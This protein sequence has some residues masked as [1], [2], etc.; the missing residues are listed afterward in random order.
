MIT[1]RENNDSPLGMLSGLLRSL[2]QHEARLLRKHF[3][4]AHTDEFQ[5]RVLELIDIVSAGD[6]LPDQIAELLGITR[7][8]LDNLI[9]IALDRLTFFLVSEHAVLAR[10]NTHSLPFLIEYEV[11]MRLM[12]AKICITRGQQAMAFR[13]LDTAYRRALEGEDYS[14]AAEVLA[15]KMQNLKF[16]S[17]S[18]E[19]KKLDT[20]HERLRRCAEAVDRAYNVYADANTLLAS[21]QHAPEQVRPYVDE[22][23]A[24]AAFSGSVQVKD[25]SLKMRVFYCQALHQ[26]EKALELSYEMLAMTKRSPLLSGRQKNGSANLYVASS[27]LLCGQYHECLRFLSIALEFFQPGS[28]NA[29]LCEELKYYALFYM[30]EYAGAEKAISNVISNSDYTRGGWLENKKHYL[31]A[32]ALFAQERYGECAR[33]LGKVTEVQK[34]KTGWNFGMRYMTVMLTV[35]YGDYDRLLMLI[36]VYE[37]DYMRTQ[38]RF[39]LRRREKLI[40]RLFTSLVRTNSFVLTAEDCAEDLDM[41]AGS[42]PDVRWLIHSHEILPVHE[43][44]WQM[45]AR[46]SGAKQRGR[47]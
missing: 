31:L 20:E 26:Y 47:A 41:L 32:C 36:K 45:H 43:W 37:R 21:A 16:K 17:A 23:D 2:P 24:L 12:A 6:R 28:Y 25:L 11:R 19:G 29:C 40:L 10:K 44:F 7:R 8:T 1:I 46:E 27:L 39:R 33:I 4:L 38:K 42:D 35:A 18:R 14:S 22:L 13:T 34:D 15:L 30:T 3:Q 9:G 5:G